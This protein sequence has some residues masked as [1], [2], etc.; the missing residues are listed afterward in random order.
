MNNERR[1]TKKFVEIGDILPM[2]R[3]SPVRDTSEDTL[4]LLS[5][6]FSQMH[7]EDQ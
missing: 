7:I 6:R 4:H 3:L 5:R 1:T 2:S